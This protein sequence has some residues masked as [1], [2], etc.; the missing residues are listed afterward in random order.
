MPLDVAENMFCLFQRPYPDRRK[1]EAV[2]NAL[3]GPLTNLCPA[4]ILR[5]HADMTTFLDRDS[6]SLL[7]KSYE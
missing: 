7:E 5:T 3:E 4:S 2:R 1:A 6:A